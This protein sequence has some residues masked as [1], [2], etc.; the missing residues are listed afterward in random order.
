[1]ETNLAATPDETEEMDQDL[2]DSTNEEKN[3]SSPDNGPGSK[4]YDLE[5]TSNQSIN[6]SFS[7]KPNYC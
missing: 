2:K 5:T 6:K 3:K 7:L 1:M 4:V